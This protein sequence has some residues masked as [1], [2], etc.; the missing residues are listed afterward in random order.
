M[1]SGEETVSLLLVWLGSGMLRMVLWT[2]KTPDGG[3]CG[4]ER[5]EARGASLPCHRSSGL[6]RG[7]GGGGGWWRRCAPTCCLPR[8]T[9]TPSS[10]STA[11]RGVQVLHETEDGLLRGTPA[12]RETV[13]PGKHLRTVTTTE[14]AVSILERRM[15]DRGSRLLLL[16]LLLGWTEIHSHGRIPRCFLDV[17][18]RRSSVRGWRKMMMMMRM[19][20]VEGRLSTTGVKSVFRMPHLSG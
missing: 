10:V 9:P 3:R 20:Q 5:L 13:A 19:I 7:G 12:Q 15:G 1:V 14:E 2:G 18:Q 4:G 16:L 17:D 11:R 8:T 6:C